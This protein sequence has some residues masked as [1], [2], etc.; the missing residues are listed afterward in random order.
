MKALRKLLFASLMF[1]ITVQGNAQVQELKQLALNIE[2][3]AQFRAILKDMKEGYEILTKGYN[4]VKDLTEGNFD[5]HKTF[6]DALL[7]VSPA[8][9]NYKRV[10][11]I[12][13]YQVEL[14]GNSG[15]QRNKLQSSGLFAPEE[16]DYFAQVYDRIF[17]ESLRDLEELTAVLTAGELRMSDEERLAAIDRIYLSVQD[18][19]LFVRDFNSQTGILALQRGREAHDVEALRLL[20][21]TN[22]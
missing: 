6:L 10:G 3:L 18:K 13:D 1:L 11:E 8:V 20:T 16:L 7:Q 12:I 17:R 5:L 4:T 22:P 21:Q 15:R 2:K 14:V 9:R 19:C